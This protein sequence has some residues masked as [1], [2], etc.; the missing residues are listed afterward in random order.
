MLLNCLLRLQVKSVNIFVKNIASTIGF[1]MLKEFTL[2][3]IHPG[4]VSRAR[5]LIFNSIHSAFS[6]T[7][8]SRPRF[9]DLAMH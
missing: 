6:A 1:P 2:R 3:V 5:L 7:S 8:L 9:L 4:S